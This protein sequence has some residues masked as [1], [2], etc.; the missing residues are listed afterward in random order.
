MDDEFF[1]W[2]CLLS[3]HNIQTVLNPEVH[4]NVSREGM[5]KMRAFVVEESLNSVKKYST[6]SRPKI[7]RGDSWS[8][9][10]SNI[11]MYGVH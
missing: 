9:M 6:L 7:D 2:S 8:D 4:T 1:E 10:L 3:P 11:V 5:Q